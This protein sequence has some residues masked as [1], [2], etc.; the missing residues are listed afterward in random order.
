MAQALPNANLDGQ[1]EFFGEVGKAPVRCDTGGFVR[2]SFSGPA[3]AEVSTGT[4]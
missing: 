1:L 2:A 4:C 3:K